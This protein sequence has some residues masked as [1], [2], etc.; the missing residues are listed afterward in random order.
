MPLCLLQLYELLKYKQITYTTCSRKNL[1]N[2]HF[3]KNKIQYPM[4]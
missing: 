1:S 3:N 2:K 4:I